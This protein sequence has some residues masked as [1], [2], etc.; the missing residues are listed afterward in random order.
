MLVYLA[1]LS[2]YVAIVLTFTF[3]HAMIISAIM[4]WWTRCS[5]YNQLGLTLQALETVTT[6]CPLV[7]D[8][9]WAVI[10]ELLYQYCFADSY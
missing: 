9:Q 4:K 5:R 10:V 2:T 1:T 3:H 7:A 6:F 8:N